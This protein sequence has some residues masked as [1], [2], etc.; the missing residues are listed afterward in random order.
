MALALLLLL[1]IVRI[2]TFG[3]IEFFDRHTGATTWEWGVWRLWRFGGDARADTLLEG[4]IYSYAF[5]LVPLIAF[6]VWARPWRLWSRGPSLV[7]S[8]VDGRHRP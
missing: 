1:T 2:P 4:T 8:S 7:G 6:V 5:I 3:T